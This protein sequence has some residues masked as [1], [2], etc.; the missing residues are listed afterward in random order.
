MEALL[1]LLGRSVFARPLRMRQPVAPNSRAVVFRL[2]LRPHMRITA[3]AARRRH[4]RHLAD[5]GCG[6]LDAWVDRWRANDAF[7]LGELVAEVLLRRIARRVVAFEPETLLLRARFGI[8]R[9]R[10]RCRLRE[11]RRRQHRAN[12]KCHDRAPRPSARKRHCCFRFFVPPF[13]QWNN[14]WQESQFPYCGMPCRARQRGGC[15]VPTIWQ[16]SRL[17]TQ[18]QNRTRMMGLLSPLIPTFAS[19]HAVRPAFRV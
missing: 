6:R 9:L 10:R 15:E 1:I 7:G 4:D 3:R 14:G 12:H 13:H 5:V 8:G 2:S 11:P 17:G 19:E 16:R 18:I